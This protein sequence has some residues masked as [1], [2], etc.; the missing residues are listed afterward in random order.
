[1]FSSV[2]SRLTPAMAEG[3]K[4]VSKRSARTYID[5]MENNSDHQLTRVAR[6]DE[7]ILDERGRKNSTSTSTSSRSS[8]S[9]R[10][11]SIEAPAVPAVAEWEHEIVKA[12]PSEN[13]SYI[14]GPFSSG[15]LDPSGALP[16]FGTCATNSNINMEEFL[17]TTD[18]PSNFGVVVPGVYR[19]SFPK[20]EDHEFI[21]GLKLKTIVLV[22]RAP[23]DSCRMMHC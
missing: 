9:S 4:A 6:N 22:I 12:S 7:A 13:R 18:R 10:Q 15:L 5:D 14:D 19:S 23:C 17:P 20:T 16:M 8:Q 1:M 2:L 21:S 3:T 11:T